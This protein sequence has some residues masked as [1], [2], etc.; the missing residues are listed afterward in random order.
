M[1]IYIRTDVG[2]LTA[3]L[4]GETAKNF[5]SKIIQKT[6]SKEFTNDN[7]ITQTKYVIVGDWK[8][9]LKLDYQPFFGKQFEVVNLDIMLYKNY[10]FTIEE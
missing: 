3:K 1:T 5:L 8:Y 7:G 2:D 6:S 9:P 4:F 10:Y